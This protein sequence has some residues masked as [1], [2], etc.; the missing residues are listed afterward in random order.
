MAGESF[1]NFSG[2][3]QCQSIVHQVLGELPIT[4]L[5]YVLTAICTLQSIT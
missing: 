5:T 3:S 4:V 2:N 1:G